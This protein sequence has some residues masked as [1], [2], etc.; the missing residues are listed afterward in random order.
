MRTSISLYRRR[1]GEWRRGRH[2]AQ[3]SVSRSRVDDA[4][5]CL[6]ESV[7]PFSDNMDDVTK[8]RA[9]QEACRLIRQPLLEYLAA[10]YPVEYLGDTVEALIA[11]GSRGAQVVEHPRQ[12][13][14]RWRGSSS[15]GIWQASGIW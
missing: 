13:S 9:V 12:M 6:L 7:G 5:F 1:L 3:I 10:D 4:T 2:W 14:P 8:S 15:A 11:A